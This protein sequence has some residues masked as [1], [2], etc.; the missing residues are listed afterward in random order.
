MNKIIFTGTASGYPSKERA[1]SSFILQADGKLF[2]FDAGEGISGSVQRLKIKYNEIDKVFISHMHPDHIAGIFMELQLMY[3]DNRKKP[4]DIYMPNESLK[5]M[6]KAIDMF[7]L[8]REKFPFDF[9]LIPVKPNPVYRGN[10]FT[11]FAYLNEHFRSNAQV[12]KKFR[13]PNKMQSYSY[14]ININGKRIFYSGDI[15]NENDIAGLLDDIHTAII[16]GLHVDFK[17]L[18]EICALNKIKRLVLTHLD[19]KSFSKPDKLFN[20]AQKAGLK[21]LVIAYDGLRLVI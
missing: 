11:L 18:A 5:G 12:I 6:E 1:C 14:T 3:L 16:E 21:K 15:Q 10:E 20:I 13:K 2:Q 9:K 7:Y 19:E 4:L 17:S 8:F